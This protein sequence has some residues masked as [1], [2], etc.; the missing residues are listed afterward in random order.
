MDILKHLVRHSPFFS[1]KFKR[2]SKKIS[3]T[4]D[5]EDERYNSPKALPPVAVLEERAMDM[6]CKSKES[7]VFIWRDLHLAESENCYSVHSEGQRT[8]LGKGLLAPR[9]QLVRISPV[10][11]GRTVKV[12][13]EEDDEDMFQ[14]DSDDEDDESKGRGR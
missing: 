11:E 14:Y 12:E 9:S 3:E 5:D 13:I 1:S 6:G 10:R 4:S 8:S 7:D 2:C